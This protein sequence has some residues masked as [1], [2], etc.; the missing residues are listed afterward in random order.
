MQSSLTQKNSDSGIFRE[1]VT[2]CY[3][4]SVL[5]KETKRTGTQVKGKIGH[6]TSEEIII[7]L[8]VRPYVSTTELKA[9]TLLNRHKGLLTRELK[10]DPS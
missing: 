3:H 8:S 5:G 10:I 7:G 6:G 1:E 9:K 4:R 2:H